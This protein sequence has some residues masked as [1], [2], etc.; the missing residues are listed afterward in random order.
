[1]RTVVI[2]VGS[3]TLTDDGVGIRAAQELTGRV[4]DGVD[5]TQV[6]AGGL[7]LMEAMAGYDRA[8]VIDALTSGGRPPGTTVELDAGAG[9]D[10]TGTTRNLTSVHDM[11]L[12]FA[13]DLGRAAG[14]RLPGEIH[15]FGVEAADVTTFGDVL[16][17]P[18]AAAVPA[19]V[20]RVLSLLAHPER[21]GS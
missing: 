13:L 21:A 17:P 18:V 5:V 10:A 14:V 12:P 19:L 20:E 15:V 8:V 4:G 2:G 6:Y 16:S 9:A 7:R 1:M 11:S 3:P